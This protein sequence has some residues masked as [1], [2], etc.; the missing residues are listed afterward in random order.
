MSKK[1]AI[2][3]I[4]KLSKEHNITV[5]EIGAALLGTSLKEKDGKWLTRLRGYLGGAFIFGGLALLAAMIWDDLSSAAR[6][7]ISYGPGL[8]SFILGIMTVKDA[9]YEKASTPL[10]I[11]SAF[12]L[13]TGMFVFLHEYA[14]GDDAQ[15]AAMIVFGILAL[16][17]MLA[18]ASLR[19]A[20]L[21]FFGFLFWLSALGILMERANV[22]GELI[23]LSMGIATLVFAARVDKTKN[24][25]ISPFYYFIGGLGF[26]WAAFD[27]IE[28]INGL[29]ILYLPV[30]ICMMLLSTRLHSRTLL[31]V[32]TFALLGYLGYFTDQY[33]ADVVGWP[34]ALIFLGFL[35][36]GISAKA[37]KLGQKIKRK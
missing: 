21:L 30:T 9:R 33:F 16:Q 8:I 20:S 6:V 18:F 1:E 29:D 31:L 36:I 37:V 22:P 4:V 15:L 12:L 19:R 35:M 7:T 32:S 5:D 26:L 2:D 17:F 10:F 13:P 34:V 3:Q 23:G 14:D 28:D 25:A 27:I 24:R 11:K